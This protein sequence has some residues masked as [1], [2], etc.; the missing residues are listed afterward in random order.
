MNLLKKFRKKMMPGGPGSSKRSGLTP[1]PALQAA[2]DI[3]TEKLADNA[4]VI[5]YEF[6]RL[7]HSPESEWNALQLSVAAANPKS[8]RYIN[9]MPFD[10][11]R[12]VLTG[13]SDYINASVLTSKAASL[14]PWSYIVTQGPLANTSAQFWQ[15][16]LEQRTAVIVM[17]TRVTEK[18]AEKCAQ[19]FPLNLDEKIAFELPNRTISVRVTAVRDLDSDICLR[20]LRVTDSATTAQHQVCHYHYHRWPDFGIPSSP[21]PLRRLAHLLDESDNPQAGSPVVHCSAGIG[22]TGT[23]V[24]IDVVLKRLRS[25]D[26]KDIKGAEA[27]VSMKRLVTHLRKQRLGMVQTVQQYVFI[28]QALY[29]EITEAFS[30]SRQTS[31]PLSRASGSSMS[32]ASGSSQG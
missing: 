13:P 21:L 22:R 7:K 11:N 27:A 30:D 16:V 2:L 18:Q 19:Y 29:D 20:E 32:R 3:I 4:K 5:G 23:F 9:V 12:V 17:L 8:N 15:M 14:P 25:L 6:E 26:G 31:Q 24:A 10:Q 1:S 28:Y